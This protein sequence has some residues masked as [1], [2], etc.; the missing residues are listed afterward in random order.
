MPKGKPPV[1]P[2]RRVTSGP[3]SGSS[4]LGK[5][6]TPTAGEAASTGY[7]RQSGKASRAQSAVANAR[8]AKARKK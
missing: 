1:N 7:A 2:N 6:W 5:R 8:V 3:G 4:N